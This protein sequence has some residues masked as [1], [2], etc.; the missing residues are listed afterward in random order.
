[1]SLLFSAK[2]KLVRY[3]Y[4]P[5]ANHTRHNLH[6]KHAE[7]VPRVWALPVAAATAV[8]PPLRF[9]QF[10]SCGHPFFASSLRALF[11]VNLG[12]MAV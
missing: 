6:S 8:L 1:M 9:V 10:H 4:N 5:T 3:L 11:A 12:R 2:A 7:L